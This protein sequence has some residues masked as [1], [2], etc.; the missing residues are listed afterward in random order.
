M[1]ELITAYSALLGRVDTW[2]AGC[3][4]RHGESIACGK[5]CSECCHGLFDITLLDAAL[6]LQGFERLPEATRKEV[7]GRCEAILERLRRFWPDL[8]HPFILN[9]REEEAWEEVMPE[10]DDTPCP[11]LALDGSCLLYDYRP[12]T[13]RLNGLPLFNLDGEP[14][15]DEWCTNN[16]I[17]TDVT[18]LTDLRFGFHQLFRDELAL[19]HRFTQRLIGETHSELDTL[20]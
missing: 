7:V 1:D 20:I 17:D 11:L 5:G 6:L 19:F 2:F 18:L 12:M 16:F 4:A 3:M 10:D 14:F 13:C 9:I 15:H 8:S